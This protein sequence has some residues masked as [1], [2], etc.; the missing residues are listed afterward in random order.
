VKVF[1]AIVIVPA[2]GLVE[3]FAA[4]LYPTVPLPDPVAPLVTVIHAALLVAVQLQPATDVTA[5][6]PLLAPPATETLAGERLYEQV[7]PAWVTVNV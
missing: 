4:T 6:V 2:R 5:T 1:P 3:G 7:A